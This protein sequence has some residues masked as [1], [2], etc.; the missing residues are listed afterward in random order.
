MRHGKTEMT[1]EI[2][3]TDFEVEIE[4]Y[5]WPGEKAGGDYPGH[6]PEAELTVKLLGLDIDITEKIPDM[7]ELQQDI[8]EF[9]GEIEQGEYEAVEEL[10]GDALRDAGKI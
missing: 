5:V 6:A 10:K 1:L 9:V 8:L 7:E 2:N 4:Y 3:G